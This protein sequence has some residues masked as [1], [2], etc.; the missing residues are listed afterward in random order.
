MATTAGRTLR[1]AAA[2]CA[3]C[4][5]LPVQARAQ[6]PENPQPPSTADAVARETG[7]STGS[8]PAG[9]K[10]LNE[11]S[12]CDRECR[13]PARVWRWRVVPYGWVPGMEGDVTVRGVT[14]P[15]DVSIGRVL[16]IFF[17]DL[18]AA[19]IIQL[20]GSN[21]RCGFL[22]NGVYADVS[23]GRQVRQL[24]FS[25]DFRTTILDLAGTLNLEGLPDRLGLPCGS[26]FELLAGV[27]YVALSAGLT[28]TGPRGN[29]VSA[30]GTEDWF[31]PIIGCRAR[32]PLF[33][34]LTG[35]LRGDIGGLDIGEAPRFTWNVEAI[36]EYQW[37]TRCS[38]FG[39]YR[40]LDIDRVTGDG[41]GRFGFDMNLNGPL[42]GLAIDF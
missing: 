30:S 10:I 5:L 19:G 20:E 42:L 35:Q 29:S 3:V 40:W 2:L 13:G 26:R 36:L 21:G 41:R 6:V 7:A 23:P 37:T 12:S 4:C 17:G 1:Q 25:S 32:V 22:F 39:G 24:D 11:A 27:R 38:L 8:M 15:V 9:F 34:R 28:V 16:D 33:E 14:A 31:D 18:N